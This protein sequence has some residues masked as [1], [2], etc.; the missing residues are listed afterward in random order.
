MLNALRL[1]LQAEGTKPWVM[2]SCLLGAGLAEGFGIATLLPLLTVA[3]GGIG[4]G[5]PLEDAFNN[6]LAGLSQNTAIIVL[7]AILVGGIVLKSGLT[8]LAMRYVGYSIAEFSTRLRARLIRQFLAVRWSYLVQHPTG[9]FINAV[10]AQV[11]GATEAYR[12][13]TAFVA[14]AIQTAMLMVV[15]LVVSWQM[16]LAAIVMSLLLAACLNTFV[17]AARKAGR[18]STQRNRELVTLLTETMNNLKPVKAMGRDAG[19]ARLFEQKIR[20]LRRAARKSVMSREARKNIEEVITTIFL[21]LGAFVALVAL[22]IAITDFLVVGLLLVRSIKSV[23]KVQEQFQNVALVET[24]HEEVQALLAETSAAREA[25][26]GTT[27]VTFAH[28][29]RFAGVSFGYDRQPILERVDLAIPFGRLVVVTGA[30]G[31]GKTTL[32]D[33]VLGLNMPTAGEVTIDGV[34]TGEVDLAFWRRQVG[35]VAQEIVLLNDTILNN[36]TLGDTD[37]DEAAI[38]RALELA[39]IA[40]FVSAL[41]QGLATLVGDKGATLSGGQRQR[42]ALARALVTRPKLLILDEVTSALD[43]ATEHEICANIRGLAAE[44]TVFAITHRPALLDYAD[45]IYHLAGGRLTRSERQEPSSRAPAL[46]S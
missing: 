44:T 42:I 4:G 27:Q 34:P 8:L 33:L 45:M 11:G 1:F 12:Q 30:S 43:P 31:A 28:E 18:K 25:Y 41:P 10:G 26:T 9:R 15:A 19:F 22:E 20:S 23:G 38:E 21:A 14:T 5:S 6:L 39:G 37:V 35:Y 2:I 24:L 36:I 40:E 16:S 3:Q 32:A 29:I 13:A 46:A 17:R 7:L